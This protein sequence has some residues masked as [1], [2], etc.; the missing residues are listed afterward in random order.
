VAYRAIDQVMADLMD[1]TA[2]VVGQA[3]SLRCQPLILSLEHVDL[4]A[5]FI[6]LALKAVDERL[7]IAISFEVGLRHRSAHSADVRAEVVALAR[8]AVDQAD[9]LRDGFASGGDESC[10]T[11]P[12]G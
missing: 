9:Q 6:S 2:L 12:N 3:S 8:Q 5:S 10:V 1:E 11:R 7:R 4:S